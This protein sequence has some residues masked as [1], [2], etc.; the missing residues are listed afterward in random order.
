MTGDGVNDAPAFK[1]AHIGVAMGRSGTDVARQAADLILVDDNFA[2]VVE[3][4]RE[5]RAIYRNIQ[6]FIFFLLSS[7][8][9]LAVAVFVVS[10]LKEG[11]PLTPLQILWINL[12][13]NGLPALALG[14]DPADPGHMKEHP[15]SAQAGL[16][17]AR[18]MFDIGFVGAVMG[19]A[20]AGLYI[21]PPAA[22]NGT[23][24]SC[25]P[26]PFAACLVSSVS[27]LDADRRRNRFSDAPAH[28]LATRRRMPLVGGGTSRGRARPG[29]APC[30]SHL[31]NGHSDMA[32]CNWAIVRNRS[33]G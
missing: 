7:N 10:F 13:T 20:A 11:Q 16:L 25:A 23:R 18:D 8:A 19:L 22:A 17:S 12:V 33:V 24:A 15:R 26:W 21:F 14:V 9:G 28:Q 29:A 4:I 30:F 32:S 31:S 1:Q 5:G 2:T 27:R 3:A 6:K